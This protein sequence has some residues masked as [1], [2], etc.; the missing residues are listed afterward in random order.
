LPVPEAEAFDLTIQRGKALAHMA[1]L[2]N[3]SLGRR[4]EDAARPEIERTRDLFR[5]LVSWDQQ[6][7]ELIRRTWPS[8]ADLLAAYRASENPDKQLFITDFG[9]VRNRVVEGIH[10][11]LALL[12]ALQVAVEDGA[13]PPAKSSRSDR[14]FIGHGRAPEWR[15][16][17]EFV[18]ER[19]GLSVEEFNREA[20]AGLT[21][22]QRLSTML[23]R[24]TLAVAVMTAEDESSDGLRHARENVIHEIGLFQGRLGSR[25]TIVLLERGCHVFSNLAGVQHL[26][27]EK[28][29]VSSCFE[30]LRRSFE[31]EGVLPRAR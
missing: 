8:R 5:L 11:R 22:A 30:D 28:G 1:A 2:L 12:H 20:V 3:A 15:E 7:L 14:V 10:A 6:N 16:V 29:S 9:S 17:K 21:A 25:R 26:P 19:L 27:F 13:E 18:D 23:D 4:A 31:R 24:C